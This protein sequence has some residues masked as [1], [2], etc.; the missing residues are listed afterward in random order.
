MHNPHKAQHK[1]ERRGTSNEKTN[2]TYETTGA[3]RKKN[4]H[5]ETACTYHPKELSMFITKTYLYNF[6]PRPLNSTFI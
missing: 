6:D 5:R 2:N 3:Q 1:K 4:F